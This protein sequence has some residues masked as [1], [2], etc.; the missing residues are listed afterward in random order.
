MGA[1]LPWG[2]LG[3]MGKRGRP[4]V[5]ALS[6]LLLGLATACAPRPQGPPPRTAPA[7]F[8]GSHE[9]APARA[10]VEVGLA[11]WYGAAL[12]GRRTA[13]GERFDPS[14]M[15]AAHRELPFGTWV[16]VTRLDTGQSVRVRINDRGPF[17]HKDRI[18]DLSHAAAA[19]L[20]V[21]KAGVARVEVRVVAGPSR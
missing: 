15:T 5:Q 19:Q 6:P 3:A 9:P 4:F 21:V 20:G 2:T 13:S 12:A 7:A 10:E 1:T 14:Q 8:E 11:T 18:I 17:G 16:E